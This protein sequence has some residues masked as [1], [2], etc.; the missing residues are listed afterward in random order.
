MLFAH[1]SALC[2][3]H[4]AFKGPFFFLFMFFPLYDAGVIRPGDTQRVEFK[5]KSEDPGLKTELWQLNTYPV[6]LQGASV[7]VRLS[8]VAFNQVKTADQRLFIEVDLKLSCVLK[9][10]STDDIERC[11]Q[12]NRI[13]MCGLCVCVVCV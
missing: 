10:K 3:T 6:V 7:Q 8:G 13:E 4:L 9:H 5:F 2:V 11:S 1:V 12:R